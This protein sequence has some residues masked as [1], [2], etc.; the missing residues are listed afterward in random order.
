M[1]NLVSFIFMQLIHDCVC[2][3]HVRFSHQKTHL[4]NSDCTLEDLFQRYLMLPLKWMHQQSSQ[5]LPHQQLYTTCTELSYLSIVSH[6][7]LCFG[8][9]GNQW[10]FLVLQNL[11]TTPPKNLEI[12]EGFHLD[13]PIVI[14]GHLC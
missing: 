4:F 8:P 3:F 10:Y 11:L 6:S 2:C 14:I 13:A 5:R 9:S 12:Q 7:T 1:L